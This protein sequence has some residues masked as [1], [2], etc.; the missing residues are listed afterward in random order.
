LKLPR[1]VSG[2]EAVKGLRRLGFEVVHQ[3]GSHIRMSKGNVHLTAPN[4]HQLVP[5][6]L[7]SILRH[8]EIKLEKFIEKL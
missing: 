7:Q 2:A 6:T 5:K 8:A 4:H 3:E 1:D